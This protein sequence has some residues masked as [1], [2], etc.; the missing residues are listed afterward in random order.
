[1][2]AETL[3]DRAEI[4]DLLD[5]YAYA[6]DTRDFDLVA[7]LFT[8]D[9]TLD[10]TSSG[11]PRAPRDDVVEWLRASLP[12]VALTQHLLTNRRIRIDGNTAT[13]RTELFNPLLFDGDDGTQLLLLGG[14]YTD[15]LVRTDRGWR[16]AERVHTTTWT[17]GPWPAQLQSREER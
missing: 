4:S 3:L 8:E 2:D 17:A 9:A 16:I 12:A 1:M 6:I 11:G 15:R 7:S 14:D 13:A 5:E 10:Y